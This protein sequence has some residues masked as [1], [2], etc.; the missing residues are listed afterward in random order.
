[1]SASPDAMTTA[2]DNKSPIGLPDT[3]GFDSQIAD[4]RKTAQDEQTQALSYADKAAGEEEAAARDLSAP[5][6]QPEVPTRQAA[7]QQS[8]K[9]APLLAMMMAIGGKATR[10]SGQNM[11]AA[12]GGMMKGLNEGSEARYEDAYKKWQAELEKQKARHEQQQQIHKLMLEAYSGRADAHQKAAEAAR[13]MTGDLLSDKQTGIA[14]QMDS[15][16]L[17]NQI[18]EQMDAHNARWADIGIKMREEKRKE[19]ASKA[20]ASGSLDPDTLHDMAGQYLAGDKSVFQNL[21]R[22]AQG[23]ANITALRTEIYKQAKEQGL[24]PT[25][26]ATKIAEFNG[27]SAGERTLGT[28]TANVEMAVNEAHNMI[29]LAR[30]ASRESTRSGFMP[31]AQAEQLL[32]KN[33]GDPKLARFVAS[34]NSLV[35]AYARAV[36]PTGTPAQAEK[37]HAREMLETAQ[38]SQA[39]EAVL[40]Q[41]NLEMEAARKSPGQVRQEFREGAAGDTSAPSDDKPRIVVRT[42]TVNGKKVV[43]Y[44]DGTVDYAP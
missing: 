7:Y 21:G 18:M 38:S 29:G 41:M 23:A 9:V 35:N 24:S 37:D 1:M 20:A 19:A 16:K 28:R 2:L 43:A 17:H 22:G 31:L 8:M 25:Q 44:S 5:E 32:Q 39:Y 34:N 4:T 6:Q 12:T 10:V 11:L 36:S 27:L 40:D 42:G 3:S 30:Q 13:R 15:M 26:I 33:R 14:N